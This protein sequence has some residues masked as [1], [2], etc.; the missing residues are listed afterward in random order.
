MLHAL[1]TLAEPL[2]GNG[3]PA[4]YAHRPDEANIAAAIGVTKCL[5]KDSFLWCMMF[6]SLVL[7][8]LKSPQSPPVA[9]T[10]DVRHQ[11]IVRV[12]R[13][14]CPRSL[15]LTFPYDG[16]VYANGCVK[17]MSHCSAHCAR[18]AHANLTLFK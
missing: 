16:N 4:A 1:C 10:G 2:L 15:P 12:E 3:S 8:A 9:G 5:C 17:S 6:L 13:R 18:Q 14:L 11:S 7:N